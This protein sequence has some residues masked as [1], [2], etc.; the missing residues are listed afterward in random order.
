[1]ETN[2]RVL[3]VA[4]N[5]TTLRLCLLGLGVEG[6]DVRHAVDFEAAIQSVAHDRPDVIVLDT[7][8]P[9]G[10]GV[11]T[12]RELKA[13]PATARIPVVSLVAHPRSADSI[14]SWI[15]GAAATIAKPFSLDELSQTVRRL[16]H[17][18][19]EDLKRHRADLLNRVHE[20]A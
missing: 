10:G 6:M 1:M 4:H 13:H 7:T 3:A 18:T 17:M 14:G 2:L 9:G 12:L 5:E 19:P 20:L 16:G 8:I 15:A 11:V